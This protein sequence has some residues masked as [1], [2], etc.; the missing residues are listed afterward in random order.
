MCT[1]R[2]FISCLNSDRRAVVL[3][4]SMA[5]DVIELKVG[6]GVGVGPDV[7]VESGCAF[8]K[9]RGDPRWR[10]NKADVRAAGRDNMSS[11]IGL[12]LADMS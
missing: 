7:D 9:T 2:S 5:S 8:R 4:F 11:G 3:T 6:V 1:L 10:R 12:V